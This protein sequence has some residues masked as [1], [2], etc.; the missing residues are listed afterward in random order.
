MQGCCQ[1]LLLIV[2]PGERKLVYLPVPGGCVGPQPQSD[3]LWL[4]RLPHHSHQ[5]V[6]Q[7]IEVRLV[8]KL[9]G[10]ALESF[11]R[12]VLPSVEAS[13]YE[14]LYAPSQW[15]EQGCYRE[16]GD[17]HREGGLLAGEDDEETLQHHDAAE[18]ESD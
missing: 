3:V 10:E 15:F 7:S 14:R 6:A 11:S 1:K 13:I 12:V 17:H 5:I 4:H 16:S 8:S 18:V 2:A 9:G